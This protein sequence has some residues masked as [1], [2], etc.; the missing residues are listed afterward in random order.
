MRNRHKNQGF[1][2]HPIWTFIATV[3]ATLTLL[4]AIFV[5]FIPNYTALSS[6]Q[7]PASTHQPTSTHSTSPSHQPSPTPSIPQLNPS[8]S[9]TVTLGSSITPETWYLDSQDQEGNISITIILD[10]NSLY[11]SFFSPCPG[12]ITSLGRIYINCQ[13][14]TNP[15]FDGLR[16]P[17]GHI[18][19]IRSDLGFSYQVMLK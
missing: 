11:T 7:H 6:A 14:N 1:L 3:V 19:G 2:Q 5:W 18:E 17:D 16:Y 10:P 4:L 8:Y 12:T 13:D 15:S 9:G